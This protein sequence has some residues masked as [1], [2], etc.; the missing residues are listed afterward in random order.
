MA[1]M[2]YDEFKKQTEGEMIG[3]LL[4]VA[5]EVKKDD[6]PYVAIA[7]EEIN[8]LGNPNKTEVKKHDYVV[9]FAYPNTKE[10]KEAL[11]S[12]GF[13]IKF[14]SENY[15]RFER[16]FKNAYIAPR[17]ATDIIEA[18]TRVQTFINKVTVIDDEGNL[19]ISVRTDEEMLDVMRELN[20][21]MEDA[22]YRAVGKFFRL[23]EFETDCMVLPS[24]IFNAIMIAANN[25]DLMNG[26]EVFFDLL[27]G[28]Q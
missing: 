9:D 5:E 7:D 2:S 17:Y 15:L 14:E 1:M 28:K 27:Q 19:E 10:N 24:V 26:S 25:P 18:F 22:I 11:K 4:E 16:E 13:E 3:N 12:G 23:S 21:E 6:T 8:V 20:T